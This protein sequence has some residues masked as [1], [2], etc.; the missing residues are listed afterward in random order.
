MR[1]DGRE[2]H[3][4]MWSYRIQNIWTQ[5]LGQLTYSSSQAA[6]SPKQF[7]FLLLV[8][9]LRSL[10]SNSCS[11]SLQNFCQWIFKNSLCFEEE[12]IILIYEDFTYPMPARLTK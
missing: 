1:D 6:I 4:R 10:K 9:L 3:C 2:Y 12:T 5:K 11:L 8:D 7:T